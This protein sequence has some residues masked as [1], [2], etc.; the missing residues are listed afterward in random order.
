[1]MGMQQN[2]HMGMMNMQGMGGYGMSMHAL[3]PHNQPALDSH[4]HQQEEEVP[5]AA[6]EKPPEPE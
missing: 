6:T 3:G 2:S 1:M 5:A 4:V